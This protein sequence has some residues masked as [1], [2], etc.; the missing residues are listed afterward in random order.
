MK[1]RLIDVE[2]L[3]KAISQDY[4]NGK[5]TLMEVINEQPVICDTKIVREQLLLEKM[6]FFLTIANTGNSEMDAEYKK[7]GDLID[8]IIKIMEGGGAE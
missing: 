8:E 5:K 6:N 1:M 3:K 7:L 2:K 4:L